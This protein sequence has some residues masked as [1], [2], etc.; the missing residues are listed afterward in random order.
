MHDR[1]M[2][3]SSKLP[4]YLGKTSFGKVFSKIHGY[5]TRNYDGS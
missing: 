1:R 4:T 3:L 2:M 5:L